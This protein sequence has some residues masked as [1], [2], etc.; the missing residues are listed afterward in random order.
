MFVRRSF[1]PPARGLEV[2][3]ILFHYVPL[4]SQMEELLAVLEHTLADRQ[5]IFMLYIIIVT[6]TLGVAF[7]ETYRKLSYLPKILLTI[8]VGAAVWYNF[9]AIIVNTIFVADVVK[10]IL[11][12][13]PPDSPL[14]KVLTLD[15]AHR[16][17]AE[18]VREL[19]YLYG[20]VNIAVFVSMWWDQCRSTTKTIRS[21]FSKRSAS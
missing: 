2:H 1:P 10:T 17:N 4:N 21:K 16:Y 20:F 5:N 12:Q 19:F 13:L 18:P 7:T 14:Y 6:S 8:A 3:G 15:Y 11:Q 9:Y